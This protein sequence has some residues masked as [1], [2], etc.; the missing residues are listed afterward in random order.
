M[1]L[2]MDLD[3]T[4][5]DFTDRM[6]KAGS[7]PDREDKAAFQSW[8]DRLQSEDS[9]YNDPP[10]SEILTLVGTMKRAG[11][12]IVFLTGRSQIYEN[13]TKAWL[14]KWGLSGKLFMRPETNWESARDYKYGMLK[15]IL[16]EYNP[17]TVMTIDDNP[18]NDSAEMYASLGIQFLKVMPKR[19]IV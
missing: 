9:L 11:H 5:A 13:V 15:I 12:T 4:L 16:K 17:D 14:K 2:V 10:I 3:G 19:P 7:M 8:L 1:M 6:N 18:E